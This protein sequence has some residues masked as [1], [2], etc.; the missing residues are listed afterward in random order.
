MVFYKATAASSNAWF[1]VLST[2]TRAAADR[3][4]MRINFVLPHIVYVY[5]KQKLKKE[6]VLVTVSPGGKTGEYQ[7]QVENRSGKLARV[8]NVSWRGFEKST[9]SGGFP[10]F[11][12]AT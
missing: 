3:T 9:E 10:V 11:P 8:E 7:V 6:D 4:Q 5:Q 1:T 12:R 2:L